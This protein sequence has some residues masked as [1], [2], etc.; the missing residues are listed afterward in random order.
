MIVMHC[1]YF[2]ILLFN[3]EP[4]GSSIG[5]L[6]WELV[7][8]CQLD[9]S[10]Y[11]YVQVGSYIEEGYDN[12]VTNDMTTRT[13]ECIALRLMGNLQSSLSILTYRQQRM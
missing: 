11:P 8:V 4:V 13:H 3:I 5:I 9:V 1:M 6:P 10:M 2:F 12:I 7:L